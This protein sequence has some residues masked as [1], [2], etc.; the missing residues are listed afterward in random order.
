MGNITI[1]GSKVL[2]ITST[3]SKSLVIPTT[4]SELPIVQTMELNYQL[5]NN[6]WFFSLNGVTQDVKNLLDSGYT[7]QVQLI[8]DRGHKLKTSGSKFRSATSLTYKQPTYPSYISIFSSGP[9]L[10]NKKA[11]ISI[12]S[13][14][15]SNFVN[16][17]LTN[18]INDMFY[19]NSLHYILGRPPILRNINDFGYWFI[20]LGFCILINNQRLALTLPIRLNMRNNK[21]PINTNYIMTN[22]IIDI[23]A[24]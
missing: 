7:M 9:V 3:S 24:L 16:M 6:Q 4:P 11:R 10:E 1:G 23:V 2:T 17:N 20:K 21:Q 15:G 22:N 14:Q 13:F 18:W 12:N 8:R 5:S 19:Y